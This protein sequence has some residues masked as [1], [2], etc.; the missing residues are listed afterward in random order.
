MH[1]TEREKEKERELHNEGSSSSEHAKDVVQ[2]ASKRANECA[3]AHNI[4]VFCCVVLCLVVLYVS[5]LVSRLY[6]AHLVLLHLICSDCCAAYV[7]GRLMFSYIDM[8]Y[9]S[10]NRVNA[11]VGIAFRYYLKNETIHCV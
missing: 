11:T 3:H 4:F 7:F 8:F 9:Y 6:T 1:K 10:L 2:M 5:I